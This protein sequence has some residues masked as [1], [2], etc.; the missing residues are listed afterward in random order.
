MKIYNKKRKGVGLL[1]AMA[2]FFSSASMASSLTWTGSTMANNW[3][4]NANSFTAQLDILE[5]NLD[6]FKRTRWDTDYSI[7]DSGLVLMVN[8][9]NVAA[10]GESEWVDIK[11][12]SMYNKSLLFE[13]T[14]TRT[15]DG[16][17]GGAYIF[18]NNRIYLNPASTLVF[19]NQVTVSAWIK[20]TR[21]N[22]QDRIFADGD[23]LTLYANAGKIR[24][25]ISNL[26]VKYIS[27]NASIKTGTRSHIAVT[28]DKNWGTNNYKFYYNGLL[29]SQT[30]SANTISNPWNIVIWTYLNNLWSTYQFSGIIDEF[31]M[32]D[33]AL[34]AQEISMIYQSNIAKYDTG[35]RLFS[36]SPTWTANWIYRYTW[37][38]SDGVGTTT[39]TWRNITWI[40]P[41]VTYYY[42]GNN[43]LAILTWYSG[44]TI[45]NNSW[46]NT[47]SFSGNDTTFRFIV[48]DSYGISGVVS[49]VLRNNDYFLDNNFWNWSP[50]SL[51]IINALYGDGT[52]LTD[53]SAYTRYR[54]TI[55]CATGNMNVVYITWWWTNSIPTTL[56]T[57][58][59]YV[60]STGVYSQSTT[61]N[62]VN[63]STI[64][65][66]WDVIILGTTAGSNMISASNQK[67][68]ILDNVKV[69]KYVN[70]ASPYGLYANGIA[71]ATI[72]NIEI[73]WAIASAGIFYQ[74][75]NYTLISNSRI[76]NNKYGV[77]YYASPS[78]FNIITNS[79]IFNNSNDGITL[80]S[81][82]GNIFDN[83]QIYNNGTYGIYYYQ[84]SQKNVLN[85][86]QIYNNANWIL[87]GGTNPWS[88]IINN[89]QIYN[90]T[91]YGINFTSGSNNII[92]NSRVYN[93]GTTGVYISGISL[94]NKY[95]GTNKVFW[96]TTNIWWTTTNLITWSSSDYPSLGRTDGTIDQT[97]ILSR[98]YIT[99]PKNNTNSYL[100]S[101]SGTLSNIRGNKTF[102]ATTGMDYSY[103][104][105]ILLQKQAVGYLTWTTITNQFIPVTTSYIG[106]F[107]DPITGN[108]VGTWWAYTPATIT[109]TGIVSSPATKYNIFWD[110]STFVYGVDNNTS[111]WFTFS[112][113]LTTNKVVIQM[114]DPTN[115]FA[116]H[117]QITT[118][119]ITY[120]Y[121]ST[122]VTIATL[123]WYNGYTIIN[124][125]GSNIYTLTGTDT[126][127]AN[128]RRAFQLQDINGNISNVGTRLRNNDSYINT[129]F[130][131]YTPN[132]TEIFSALYGDGSGW[133]DK[134]AYTQNRATNTCLL[135]NTIRSNLSAGTDQLPVN[136][137]ANTMYVL[138]SWTYL[139]TAARNLWTCSAIIGKWTVIIQWVFVTATNL[140]NSPTKSNWI[141]DN[142]KLNR[143]Y[144]GNAGSNI[145]YCTNS[146]STTMNNV[147]AYGS[148]GGINFYSA[149]NY[150]T[151][152]NIS[153]HDNAGTG[154]PINNSSIN[155]T[156]SN[157]E[158]YNNAA[159][160]IYISTSSA[161]ATITNMKSRNNNVG[162][163][164]TTSNG[165]VINNSQAYNNIGIWFKIVSPVTINNSQSYNNGS[166]GFE[167]GAAGASNSIINNCQS[168]NNTNYGI[169][170]WAANYVSINNS[171]IYN[172]STAW[173]LV[174]SSSNSGVINNSQIYNNGTCGIYF[175]AGTGTVINNSQI[176]NNA[177][178]GIYI[179]A[180]APNTRYYG[181]N[182]I[183]WNGTAALGWITANLKTWASSDYPS[184]SRANGTIDQTPTMSRDYITNPK[185]ASGTH[186]LNRSWT[187]TGIRSKITYT[188][189][190][191]MQYSYG[192]GTLSQIQ[193]VTVNGSLISISGTFTWTNY[194]WSLTDKATGDLLGIWWVNGVYSIFTGIANTPATK[195]NIFWDL[196]T[197]VYSLDSN[198]STGVTFS[199][200][201]VSAKVI[202]QLYDPANYFAT[203]FQ[204]IATIDRVPPSTPTL[205]SPSSGTIFATWA[206]SLTWSVATDT[207]VGM[208]WYFYQVSTNTGF[209]SFVISGDK[210]TT[211]VSLIN[212]TDGTYYRRI[213]AYDAGGITWSRWSTGRFIVDTSTPNIV[214]T[215]S[216][217]IDNAW[218]TNNYFTTQLDITE[219]NFN[220]FIRSR[221]GTNYSIYDSG[222]VVMMNFDKVAALSET[223]WLI[224]DLS[225][226]GNNGSGY[227]GVTRTVNGK[228]NGAYQFD[229]IND[230]I[231]LSAITTASLTNNFTISARVKLNAMPTSD[232]WPFFWNSHM[233]II[234]RWSIG[235]AD[236]RDLLVGATKI[237]FQSNDTQII[238]GNHNM[239]T[240]NRYN[241]VMTRNS[242]TVTLF[243]N[244]NQIAQISSAASFGT[245]TSSYIGSETSQGAWFNWA[246]DEV[247]VYNRALS[248]DEINTLYNS[249]LNK[250][251]TNKRTFILDTSWINSWIFRY[252]GYV[253]DIFGNSFSTWRQIGRDIT[254]PSQVTLISPINGVTITTGQVA[255]IRS[256]ATDDVSGISWYIYEISNDNV[257]STIVLSGFKTTT[258][259]NL[260]G[261]DDTYY[262][263]VYAKDNV[264]NSWSRSTTFSFTINTSPNII[265][266]PI[267]GTG[268]ISVW[269]TWDDWTDNY[270]KWT[271]NIKAF[272][273][274]TNI[275]SCEYSTGI[276]RATASTWI[277]YCEA[278]SLNPAADIHVQFRATNSAGTT[279]G[280]ITTYIYD[281][282]APSAP[283]AISP[284]TGTYVS[285]AQVQLL[286]SGSIDT[287][288][289]IGG[290][291]YEVIDN[292]WAL[293]ANGTSSTTGA[294]IF[295]LTDGLYTWHVYAYDKVTNTW[296]RSNV[297][298][299]GYLF[300]F[301][302]TFSSIDNQ[303]L[304]QKFSSVHFAAPGNNFVGGIFRLTTKSLT[305]NETIMIAGDPT[306]RNCNKQVRGMYFNSQRGKRV[307]PLDQYT[308]ALLQQTS[309]TY[310]NLQM[311]GGL[312][313]S[314]TGYNYSIY[315][316]ISYNQSGTTSSIVAGT[317]LDYLRN[318]YGF[319]GS[320]HFTD[321]L[322]YFNNKTP[323]GFIR[324][325]FGGIGF[326]GGIMTGAQDLITY[327]NNGWT[328]NDAFTQTGTNITST[329]GSRRFT[330]TVT[331]D[332]ASNVIRN[333]LV[334]WSVWLS[335]SMNEQDRTSLLG[336]PQKKTIIVG[337]ENIN[338]ATLINQAKQNMETLCKGKTRL[339]QDYLSPSND[340][341]LC[342]EQSKLYIDLSD[343][344]LYHDKTIIMR[345]GAVILSGSM[346]NTSAGLDL[347]IDQWNL[348]LRNNPANMQSFDN[349]WYIA[350]STAINSGTLLRGN[351]IINGLIL[352]WLP[353]SGNIAWYNHKLYIQW[354]ISSLNTPFEPT[355]ARIDFISDVIWAGFD[356]R[357][358]LQNVFVRTCKLNGI[359]TDGTSCKDPSEMSA[360]P[361]VIVDG[362]YP[363]RLLDK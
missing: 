2:C 187:F 172:N 96:N 236:W 59:I 221:S 275:T 154:I 351:I 13:W 111:T 147:E 52:G 260:S 65:G 323:I 224:K 359:G 90:N 240:S 58:T 100:S 131:N 77:Q 248:T 345:S 191:P 292:A 214:F 15:S 308:L 326:V 284:A 361:L 44:L 196:T 97:N 114:Y 278:T 320:L 186:V 346:D 268:Y 356:N 89:T 247:R 7:Y 210:T 199:W 75:S 215:W 280:G 127:W 130:W 45:I 116:T 228:R 14:N 85:N 298:D 327:I 355:Q 41:R 107:V 358:W 36:F 106:G 62:I 146:S 42:T 118:P 12:L 328:I 282:V 307:W 319:G 35:K 50:S 29:D 19:T 86:S 234:G 259:V 219:A 95:Y 296:A 93:N 325:S 348:Y 205:V 173:I 162:F 332:N 180:A 202:T 4:I 241:I 300:S 135:T 246:I 76:Y 54:N 357:I 204:K 264:G 105:G 32:Y 302:I 103:G 288:A 244:N 189:I 70:S 163:W 72:N 142:L 153:V 148:Y 256:W 338:N 360:I 94:T 232:A 9:D 233:V 239:T 290:Y 34:S 193:P 257:F 220:Q 182:K 344:S 362:K 160:G 137:V 64:V 271:I 24:P 38:V 245:G 16:K 237:I 47:H 178:T 80:T 318:D 291:Y 136:L 87:Y 225:L 270:Y 231:G 30:T 158:A 5:N 286:R 208:W 25:Y 88:N 185:N 293:A 213:S 60:L 310:D 6:Q 140:L 212:F 349:Q 314:C 312:F 78:D 303:S 253:N 20:P 67:N 297:Q 285:S 276:S 102:V 200:W 341:V 313:T 144:S 28:Y 149:C 279:T 165:V 10:I 192:S 222:L 31:R 23:N 132:T 223:D 40:R 150:G 133:V 218:I 167:L 8:F 289:G 37:F 46:L 333:L 57:N 190:E 69:Y 83:C 263:R 109:I 227:G 168:Y 177:T 336:N 273:S 304:A 188:G 230:Y 250:Y 110:L 104:S 195:Y 217:P 143:N 181:T 343:E 11:D 226:S 115:Y 321:G 281:T 1:I 235:A 171:Q 161:N 324:D 274:G 277:D 254:G 197:F 339:I 305:G 299:F 164:V 272:V 79:K 48:Q 71:S 262:R 183:F 198:I 156:V 119:T 301:D 27:T 26:T 66:Q 166:Y 363:S 155:C 43:W 283:T 33:R 126:T 101:W 138:D 22:D 266:V 176:F 112:D 347:F 123:T 145:L 121:P 82:T 216:T 335:Q 330:S 134:S 309:N 179:L 128:L 51:D 122:G 203:H 207:W 261:V 255:L 306:E 170:L 174:D 152:N 61:L 175:S 63:C 73:S 129:N 3:W 252:T 49:S 269:T 354:K 68:R 350:T 74:L 159:Y 81:S 18:K 287:G 209:T 39:T 17:R 56:T 184:L 294:T 84:N 267:V 311:S 238:S 141:L 295:G 201:I 249:N 337:T 315:G 342:F 98:D 124:N 108:I 157:S 125:G 353:G 206:V 117:Y 21:L 242:T 352:W 92:N 334:Q 243:V 329:T 251:T 91:N 99:N 55:T 211:G 331:W 322:Q 53:R 340:D 139:T 120:T 169:S 194:I 317:T 151:L 265:T 229:G 113:Q 316:Q 258:G